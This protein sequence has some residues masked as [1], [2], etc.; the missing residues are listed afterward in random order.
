VQPNQ[1]A[2]DAVHEEQS[3]GGSSVVAQLAADQPE[4][5]Q[6]G[7]CA[8]CLVLAVLVAAGSEVALG[9]VGPG[10]GRGHD[11]PKPPEGAGGV[12]AV[13]SLT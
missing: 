10:V 12:R 8:C 1:A 11:R 3:R 5:G 6:A 7:L 13:K 2:E 4:L 9:G